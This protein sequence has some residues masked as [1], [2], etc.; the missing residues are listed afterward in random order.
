LLAD[1][2]R[3]G[4]SGVPT[5]VFIDST[6]DARRIVQGLMEGSMDWNGFAADMGKLGVQLR[7]VAGQIAPTAQVVSLTHFHD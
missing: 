6:P 5:N 4:Q 7:I 3:R 1:S 2:F